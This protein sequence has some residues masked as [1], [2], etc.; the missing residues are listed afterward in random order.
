M[1][2]VG[3]VVL[4]DLTKRY[5][6]QTVVNGIS[7][8]IRPG[9][10]VSILGPSGCGKTTTL[11]M[12]AGLITP[13]SG[14]I[15]ISGRPVT[16]LPPWDRNCGFVFQSYALFPHLTV[17][18]NIA[19]GLRIR[20][21][22]QARIESKVK[23][24]ADILGLAD[25]LQ[26][27]PR[28][29]SGGQQQRVAVARALAIEPDVM[30]MDEPL[31]NLDAKL[32]E[33]V[34][35]ELRRI[36]TQTG[37]TVVYVTHDQAEAFALSDRVIVMNHGLVDQIGSPMEVYTR[38]DSAF[39]ASFVGSNN[40]LPV[41]ILESHGNTVSARWGD[42]VL[43][44]R[45]WKEFSPGDGALAVIAAQ[46][47]QLADRS[48]EGGRNRLVGTLSEM[49]FLGTHYRLVLQTTAGSIFAELPRASV[50]PAVCRVGE[51][52]T[53]SAS[54]VLFILKD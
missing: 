54:E 47:F 18:E 11:R 28:M 21:W 5:N 52:V 25:F 29:L 34:R 45:T 23:E 20:K 50:D 48:G 3:E 44:G 6:G 51:K 46:D 24:L 8:D 22:P 4:R 35:F 2:N 13:D 10:F 32:R 12:I 53:L 26:R 33:H 36:Q 17:F 14:A 40:M 1:G 16:K 43:Q 49:V 41:E 15:E 7:I 42:Q 9:E 39:V 31:A 27:R 38:P 30:L 19:Y 37:V